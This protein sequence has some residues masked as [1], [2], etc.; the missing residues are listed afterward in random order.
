VELSEAIANE[1]HVQ[2]LWLLLAPFKLA[3]QF[4]LG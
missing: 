1:A 4:E 3:L 2:P